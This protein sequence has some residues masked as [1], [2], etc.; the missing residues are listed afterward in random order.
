MKLCVYIYIYID[1]CIYI[2]IYTHVI[3]IYIYIY[4]W[5]EHLGGTAYLE[6][7]HQDSARLGAWPEARPGER[8]H[9]EYVVVYH[10]TV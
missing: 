10:S 7:T 1:V 9:S 6:S 4:I 5:A 3:H 8:K 2:Y